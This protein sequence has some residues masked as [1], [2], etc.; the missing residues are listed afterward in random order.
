[1]KKPY[2]RFPPKEDNV[3]ALVAV[4]AIGVTIVVL[5]VVSVR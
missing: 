1:M 5:F 2:R 4:V 3:L